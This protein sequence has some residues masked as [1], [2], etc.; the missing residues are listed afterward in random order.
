MSFFVTFSCFSIHF[1]F[2]SSFLFFLFLLFF[3]SFSS[4]LIPFRLCSSH[5]SYWPRR[6][7]RRGRFL[8]HQRRSRRLLRPQADAIGEPRVHVSA[9]AGQSRGGVGEAGGGWWKEARDCLSLRG[10]CGYFNK[11]LCG[12]FY[13]LF[14]HYFFLFDL[15]YA[16]L[17]FF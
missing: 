11:L 6:Q 16:I 17:T 5:W 10:L 9:R 12:Y 1:L 15:F 8:P 3:F 4:F 7:N 13:K 2:F 14:C